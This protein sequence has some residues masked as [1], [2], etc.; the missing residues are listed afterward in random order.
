VKLTT[1]LGIG[2]GVL[3]LLSPMGLIVPDHF[4]AG[5]AWGEW[6]SED[7]KALV[8]YVPQGLERLGALW[9]AP[10]PGYAF[11]GWEGRGLTHLSVAYIVSGIVG[12]GLILAL[13]WGLGKCLIPENHVKH[14]KKEK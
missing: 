7:I 14:E 3:I 5:S 6:G 13:V 8:G 11:T 12:V 4:N 1:K 9:E 10:M 2:V